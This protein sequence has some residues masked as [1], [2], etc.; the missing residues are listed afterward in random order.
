V[1]F[2]WTVSY[3]D[4]AWLFLDRNGNAKVD[5]GPELFGN[6]TPQ[7][8]SGEPN[9]FI[10]LAEYDRPQSGGNSDG[11]INDRDAIFSSLR[12]WQDADHNG[13][14]ESG[15]LFTLGALNVAAVD[16]RYKESRRRDGHGNEFRYRAKVLGA[17]GAQLGRW[18]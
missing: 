6:V 16:I 1:L 17:D 5:S 3:S 15:E 11:K 13:V 14:S 7:P 8:P 9:G 10:A 2:R 4:A 12:L 18:A